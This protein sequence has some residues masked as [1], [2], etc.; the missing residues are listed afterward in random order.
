MI[1]K[2]Q[3]LA[4]GCWMPSAEMR[5]CMGVAVGVESLLSLSIRYV[6]RNIDQTDGNESLD[7][8]AR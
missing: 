4:L 7:F 6:T 3:T 1:P 8:R 2:F 5:K